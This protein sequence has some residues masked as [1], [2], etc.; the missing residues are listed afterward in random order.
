VCVV[1]VCVCVNFCCK[2]GIK[3]LQRRFNCLTKHTLDAFSISSTLS[4]LVGALFKKFGLFLITVVCT[5]A[6]TWGSVAIF[7]SQKGVHQ[8]KIFGEHCC[9]VQFATKRVCVV[10]VTNC[11]NYPTQ[12]SLIGLSNRHATYFLCGRSWPRA[13]ITFLISVKMAEFWPKWE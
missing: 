3:I 5:W 13:F 6:S 7:R 8:Q 2:L 4:V 1:C 10:L 9:S 12:H 11:D